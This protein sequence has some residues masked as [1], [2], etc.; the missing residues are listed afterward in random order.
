MTR[1]FLV[2]GLLLA[3]C[4]RSSSSPPAEDPEPGNTTDEPAPT[5]CRTDGDCHITCA[6]ADQCCDQLCEPCRQAMT[7][8]QLAAHEAWQAQ[9]CADTSCPQA[10]CMAPQETTTARCEA[11]ACVVDTTPL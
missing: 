10:R 11:G 6:V 5:G 4:P 8:D 1:A 2:L 3:G 7:T 9:S